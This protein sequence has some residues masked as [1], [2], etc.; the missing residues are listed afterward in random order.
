MLFLAKK[1][2]VK[3]PYYLTF[4]DEIYDAAKENVDFKM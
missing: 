4:S 3:K 1:F 2:L